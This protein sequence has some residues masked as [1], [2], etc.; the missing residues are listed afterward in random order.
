MAGLA[1]EVGVQL[2]LR[3]E[4]QCPGMRKTLENLRV[5]SSQPQWG[6]PMHPHPITGSHSLP[7]IALILIANTLQ[8]WN[9][10]FH[11]HLFS[12]S[13]NEDFGLIF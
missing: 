5:Q 13:Y 9:L 2:L 1:V 4:T 11:S 3:V 12:Q 6:P 7:I 10:N 8:G